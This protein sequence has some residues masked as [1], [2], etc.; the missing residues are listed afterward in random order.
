VIVPLIV[1]AALFAIG[2][3]V[4]YQVVHG[5]GRTTVTGSVVCESGRPVVG[6]WIAASTGQSD[7]GY[8]H[9]GP[10][11]SS[12]ISY[13]IGPMGT[14][15]YRLPYGGTYAVHVGCGGTSQRW[16]SSNYSPLL[17]SRT[18]NLR[19]DDPTSSAR[20]ASPRGRCTLTAV[21]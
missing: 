15:S 21:S 11:G 1:A 4:V 2:A 8:A 16:A 20:G 7:S 12:G 5:Q 17:S 13:P 18:A 9:L 14:Y 6:V 3:Y 10:P 19:C